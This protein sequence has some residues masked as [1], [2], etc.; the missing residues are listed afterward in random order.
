[1]SDKKQE[2]VEP[3]TVETMEMWK[4]KCLAITQA[5]E[6]YKKEVEEET[7]DDDDEEEEEQEETQTST[8]ELYNYYNT[9]NHI[10][11]VG[12]HNLIKAN[13]TAL[14]STYREEVYAA[15]ARKIVFLTKE[16]L[17]GKA[18]TSKVIQLIEGIKKKMEKFE[19]EA[20]SATRE[21]M[22]TEI[23][24]EAND[25]RILV[26]AEKP[27]YVVAPKLIITG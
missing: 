22:H 21:K 13:I 3:E 7:C 1:M 17:E 2:V 12:I 18:I 5:F 9:R 16:L 19:H 20:N 24:S 23:V 8:P 11:L 4:A 25:L 15:F 14:E 27:K 6:E 10:H 26:E